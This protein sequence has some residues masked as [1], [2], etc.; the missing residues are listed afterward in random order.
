[1]KKAKSG[2]RPSATRHGGALRTPATKRSAAK[3]ARPRTVAPQTVDEYC[4]AVPEPA[5]IALNQIRA[6]IR[7]VVPPDATEIISYKIPAFKH[8]KVLVWYAAFANHCSL[9]PTAAVI[10]AF[11]DELKGFSTSKGTIHFPLDKPM[12]IE[13]I[14]KMVKARVAQTESSKRR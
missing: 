11:K 6:A 9:F 13:L 8:K 14:K 10:D 1:M 5:R 2:K 7:S 3:N 4:A 12:P